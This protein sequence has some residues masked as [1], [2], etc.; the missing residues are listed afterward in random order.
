MLHAIRSRP[1]SQHRQHRQKKKEALRCSR[2]P[3]LALV[4][5]LAV[6]QSAVGGG[7][8][9]HTR[10]ARGS[11]R[12]GAG[13][14]FLGLPFGEKQPPALPEPLSLGDRVRE[15]GERVRRGDVGQLFGKGEGGGSGSRSSSSSSGSDG[16]GAKA[17][18]A[19]Q[20]TTS[21]SRPKDRSN[22]RNS[23]IAGGL[24]GSVSTTITCPIEVIALVFLPVCAED[25]RC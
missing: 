13:S 11:H 7:C 22:G 25:A 3:A 14:C 12:I 10:I 23:F 5:L 4:L 8:C 18:A 1:H 21:E 15:F 20:A 9:S 2:R 16:G 6:V 24:A 19:A 17:M